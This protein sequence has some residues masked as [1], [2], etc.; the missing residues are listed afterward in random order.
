M[1]PPFSGSIRFGAF[2]F[3]PTH[4]ELRRHGL[5]VRLTPHQLRLLTLLLEPPLRLHTRGEIQ[6]RLWPSNTFVDFEHGMNK[7]VHSLRGE[8][9]DSATNPRFIETVNATGYRF[10][11]QF[12]EELRIGGKRQL[13]ERIAVL[14][15][16]TTGSEELVEHCRRITYY[17]VD[18]LAS[19]DNLRVVA[20]AT[21][22]NYK[23][24]EMTPQQAGQTV[25][26]HAVV[27]GELMFSDGRLL[28][29][30]ELV[31]ASDGTQLCGAYAEQS[32]LSGK[33]CDR[34]LANSMVKQFRP[35]LVRSARNVEM[36]VKQVHV[37][38]DSHPHKH[39]EESEC[40]LI[41]DLVLDRQ[42]A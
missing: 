41:G 1:T 37:A 26:A 40:G 3:N 29:R 22:R 14:P 9:G 32:G 5:R 33:D 28:L 8:L 17:I 24:D 38:P 36:K 18:G 21:L 4:A 20:Q 25:D 10:I 12:A 42:G 34:E 13:P 15:F 27:S 39:F 31:D 6:Q 11:P 35:A 23:L 16:T 7:I 30:A 2:E 19:M